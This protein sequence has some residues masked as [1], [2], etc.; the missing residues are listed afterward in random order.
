LKNGVQ[1]PVTIDE[2]IRKQRLR[3][4]NQASTA[5]IPEESEPANQEQP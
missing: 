1:S 3:L 4:I 2:Q 5:Q